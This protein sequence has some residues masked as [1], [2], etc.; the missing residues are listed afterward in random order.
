MCNSVARR[1]FLNVTKLTRQYQEYLS[2]IT[3]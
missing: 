1:M 2:K 3:T